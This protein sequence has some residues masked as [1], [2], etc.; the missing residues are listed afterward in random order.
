MKKS[1]KTVVIMLAIIL[2]CGG[3]LA[4]LSDLLYVTD[5]DRINRAIQEIYVGQDFE[6][7]E[8]EVLDFTEYNESKEDGLIKS[9]YKLTNGD[10][11]VLSTGKK[12]YSNGTVTVYVAISI[13]GGVASVKKVVENSYTAQT[14]MS[15]MTSYYGEFIGISANEISDI[16]DMK[17]SGAT[18]SSRAINNAVITAL[19]YIQIEI[20]G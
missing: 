5:G 17:V 16:D 6:L 20:G 19:D 15:K 2:V 9:A 1:L 4:I 10:Y 3:L 7:D 13:E 14:L 8:T 11:L 12:G 18:G